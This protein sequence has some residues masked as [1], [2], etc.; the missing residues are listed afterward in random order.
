MEHLFFDT[1]ALVKHY[2]DEPGTEVVDHLIKSEDTKV[3]LT[4]IAVIET[5]SAFRRKYNR[6]DISEEVVDKLITAFFDEAL[7]S[8]LI[9]STEEA[10]FTHS[11][12]LILEDD[13]RTL[14]SL[15]L[16]AALTVSEEVEDIAFVSADKELVSVADGK[17]LETINPDTADTEMVSNV[18]SQLEEYLEDASRLFRILENGTVDIRTEFEDVPWQQ[19]ILI[20]LIGQQY[21]H[22]AGKADF[23][24]LHSN[25]FYN[26]VDVDDSKVRA[27]IDELSDD[28]IVRR[29]E[30]TGEWKIVTDELPKALSSIEGIDIEES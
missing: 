11:F 5:V 27:Y 19:R 8:F 16:S 15:Q 17:G 10:L 23:A 21:A 30:G 9:V 22:K 25:Y 14:D 26:R 4:A 2:Y 24:T 12:N 13:L 1:S 29:S 3:V 28:G 7:S 20:H 18:E 6:D